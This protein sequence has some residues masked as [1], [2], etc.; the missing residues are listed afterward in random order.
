MKKMIMEKVDQMFK[1]PEGFNLTLINTLF[2]KFIPF[3][4][5]HGFK[6]KSMSRNKVETYVPK[7]RSNLNH[8]G[9]I[10]AIAQATAGELSA[11]MCLLVNFGMTEYR[12]ILSHIEIEYTY[13]AKTPLVATAELSNQQIEKMKEELEG[14]EGK[15]FIDIETILRDKSDNIVSKVMTKWQLKNWKKVQTKS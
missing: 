1:N 8:L 3:N 14:D 5:P 9:T 4:A 7:K 13:Q 11:G 2:P 6:M 10:H 12:F 15:S